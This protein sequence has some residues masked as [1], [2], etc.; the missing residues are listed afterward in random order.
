MQSHS[1]QV[2]AI[3]TNGMFR[4]S[5]NTTNEINLLSGILPSWKGW[6]IRNQSIICSSKYFGADSYGKIF[7]VIPLENQ[8]IAVLSEAEDFWYIFDNNDFPFSVSQFQYYMNRTYDV[9]TQRLG[10]QFPELAKFD[11]PSKL[12]NP[13]D[14]LEIIITM[15]DVLKKMRYTDNDDILYYYT[16][17]DFTFTKFMTKPG[18]M[19][20]IINDTLNPN[21]GATLY[22]SF[23]DY[24]STEND[25]MPHEV[26]FSG[27]ALFVSVEL[28][29]RISVEFGEVVLQDKTT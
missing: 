7:Y 1:T 5:A 13:R 15:S 24:A 10:D 26:W 3:D 20:S 11:R 12:T 4:K 29:E 21:N 25:G 14:V 2:G 8:P 18:D 16:E 27:K 17:L 9:L 28:F 19:K 6:P 23:S 22:S